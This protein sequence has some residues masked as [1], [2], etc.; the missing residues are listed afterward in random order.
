MVGLL[1]R[2]ALNAHRSVQFCFPTFPLRSHVPL[3]R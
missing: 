2:F 1:Y 3:A